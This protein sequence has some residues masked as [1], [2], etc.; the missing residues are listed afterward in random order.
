MEAQPGAVEAHNG[1]VEGLLASGPDP[2][3]SRNSNPDSHQSEKR[4]L[5]YIEVTWDPQHR[6]R[7]TVIVEAYIISK[8]CYRSP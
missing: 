4:Y 8:D 7:H 6:F 5:D 2:I 1:A 3:Q